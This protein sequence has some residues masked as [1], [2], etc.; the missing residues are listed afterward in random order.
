MREAEGDVADCE[1][2]EVEHE[3]ERSED[4]ILELYSFK[5]LKQLII[6]DSWQISLNSSCWAGYQQ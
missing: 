2:E 4:Y 1:E 5:S 3:E 6:R